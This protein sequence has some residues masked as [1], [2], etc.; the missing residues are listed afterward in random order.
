M[1]VP[2]DLDRLVAAWDA[3]SPEH[4][5]E[6][7]TAD[8]T[9][10]L[11][12]RRTPARISRTYSAAQQAEVDFLDKYPQA[13]AQWSSL[14]ARRYPWLGEL[15][16]A[17][18]QAAQESVAEGGQRAF[19]QGMLQHPV[20][21]AMA[22]L[23]D[24]LS[25]PLRGAT[26]GYVDPT[27]GLYGRQAAKD[28]RGAASR[29]L[30]VVGRGVRGALEL[31]GELA[32]IGAVTK[33]V[34][35]GLGAAGRVLPAVGDLLRATP[36]ATA[37]GTEALG[38]GA[39]AG[40]R[41]PEE[42]GSRL[43]A[44]GKGL[45]MGGLLGGASR[46]SEA[47]T[48]K[49]FEGS[50]AAPIVERGVRAGL[51]VAGG[52]ALGAGETAVR[53]GSAADVLRSAAETGITFGLVGAAHA[54]GRGEKV[55]EQGL[56]ERAK[57]V[58]EA[59]KLHDDAEASGRREDV[60]VAK[61][62]V[63]AA[64]QELVNWRNSKE[65]IVAIHGNPDFK[66]IADENM[67]RSQR[68]SEAGQRLQQINTKLGELTA[69]ESAL[70]GTLEQH[71]HDVELNS[72]LDAVVAERTKL[73]GQVPLLETMQ[74]EHSLIDA[75]AKLK[76]GTV[77]TIRSL[78]WDKVRNPAADV[79]MPDG[80]TKRVPLK[81]LTKVSPQEHAQTAADA[82]A[83]A[84]LKR[85]QASKDPNDQAEF[86]ARTNPPPDASD[87]Q[88]LAADHARKMLGMQP[89]L[90]AGKPSGV[91]VVRKQ[92]I[93]EQL[94]IGRE[95]RDFERLTYNEA[96]SAIIDP[97]TGQLSGKGNALLRRLWGHDFSRWP[98]HIKVLAYGSGKQPLLGE[99][100]GH[101]SLAEQRQRRID[102][103]VRKHMADWQAGRDRKTFEAMSGADQAAAVLGPTGRPT[104]EGFKVLRG[105]YGADTRSWPAWL[106]RLTVTERPALGETE[107]VP[108]AARGR[109]GRPQEPG[110][111][112]T[113]LA[114][115]PGTG[116]LAE[117][118]DE[119]VPFPG[120]TGPEHPPEPQPEPAPE[121]E[122]AVPESEA[123]AAP[124]KEPKPSRVPPGHVMVNAEHVTKAFE[125][126]R[127]VSTQEPVDEGAV[128]AAEDLWRTLAKARTEKAP[129]P[130]EQVAQLG[131]PPPR[132]PLDS[133]AARAEAEGA[134][135]FAQ[136]VI[137]DPK[138]DATSKKMAVR[139]QKLRKT[140]L[141]ALDL[142]DKAADVG[143]PQAMKRARSA[144]DQA[145][146]VLNQELQS[147]SKRVAAGKLK[148][149]PTPE[150]PQPEPP[151]AERGAVTWGS[152][153]HERRALTR[154]YGGDAR[155]A[156]EAWRW[157]NAAG[158]RPDLARQ[159]RTEVLGETL[160]KLREYGLRDDEIQLAQLLE[161]GA[162]L[163]DVHQQVAPNLSMP[164]FVAKAA[165]VNARL[166]DAA[167]EILGK[168]GTVAP[169][170]DS[171]L[172]AIAR[173]WRDPSLLMGRSDEQAVLPTQQRL[174]ELGRHGKGNV[175]VGGV[176]N[177]RR[178]FGDLMSNT[179]AEFFDN[180]F[181]WEAR[182][183]RETHGMLL[184]QKN[185]E[186]KLRSL[187]AFGESGTEGLS[188]SWF[189]LK[190]NQL[191][192]PEEWTF[193]YLD[194][195]RRLNDGQEWT[196]EQA[197]RFKADKIQQLNDWKPGAGRDWNAATT[198]Y[199]KL[200]EHVR[201]RYRQVYGRD[202]STSISEGMYATH[203]FLDDSGNAVSYRK[204]PRYFSDP[205]SAH[206]WSRFE[207]ARKGAQGYVPDVVS[208]ARLYF[209]GMMRKIA[210]D[211][212]LSEKSPLT[213]IVYGDRTTLLRDMGRNA[214]EGVSPE[215]GIA[216]TRAGHAVMDSLNHIASSVQREGHRQRLYAWVKADS[217][218]RLLDVDGNPIK[219]AQA[220][221]GGF[222]Q[223]VRAKPVHTGD[224]TIWLR[225]AR[226]GSQPVE[227]P[228][229]KGNL[230]RLQVHRGGLLE[231]ASNYGQP[232]RLDA[233]MN[234]M[235]RMKLADKQGFWLLDNSLTKLMRTWAY[236]STLGLGQWKPVVNNLA[237]GAFMLTS[238][239]GAKPA[240]EAMA[241][242]TRQM[243]TGGD[244]NTERLLTQ[245]GVL[246][247]KGAILE[248]RGSIAGTA[249]RRGAQ[250]AGEFSFAGFSAAERFLRGSAGLAGYERAH[251]YGRA[252]LDD[253]FG[254]QGV[255][256]D[257]VLTA[258]RG[259][260][261]RADGSELPGGAQLMDLL[262]GAKLH[263]TR[264][265]DRAQIEA[266]L[267][268]R[269]LLHGRA[270][271]AKTQFLYSAAFT[272]DAFNNDVGR[273]LFQ[274]NQYP[275]RAAMAFFDA[276]ANERD[277]RRVARWLAVGLTVSVI[278]HLFD[279]DLSSAI[280]LRVG[281][282]LHDETW[283][284]E[285]DTLLAK[286]KRLA[287]DLIVPFPAPFTMGFPYV[288]LGSQVAL[289]GEVGYSALGLDPSNPLPEDWT[290]DDIWARAGIAWDDASRKLKSSVRPAQWARAM[291]FLNSP[292]DA[293][294]R[295]QV[296]YSDKPGYVTHMTPL[297]FA[298]QEALPGSRKDVYDP[299][300]REEARA[301]RE[302]ERDDISRR[303][304][305]NAVRLGSPDTTPD[306]RD[307]LQRQ[308]AQLLADNPFLKRVSPTDITR[309]ERMSHLSREVKDLTGASLP[310]RVRGYFDWKKAEQPDE[311][312][313]R[314]SL[315]LLF[316]D[317]PKQFSTRF[318]ELAEIDREAALKIRAEWSRIMSR[319]PAG[320][321]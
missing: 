245:L 257:E 175:K 28:V 312:E 197:E 125:R 62:Q 109:T 87:E 41:K 132:A 93:A 303:Y 280:G 157:R 154:A 133:R 202:I 278:A 124:A 23:G 240:A 106:Q 19:E 20:G 42:G 291:E 98:E 122:P 255:S 204:L 128:T 79:V 193:D 17:Q 228:L 270:T 185:A 100:P 269:A 263:Q 210:L 182:S 110:P 223:F 267:H 105:L 101:F 56:N 24:T 292:V 103:A 299:Y 104:T 229:T 242:M 4:E 218:R 121:P 282:A 189:G 99:P 266:E 191:S 30:G 53:G 11:G 209:P 200:W 196:R 63:A 289:M 203:F 32:P 206:V 238:Y 172:R 119:V 316:G 134:M 52:A 59:Q 75:E 187:S 241:R 321:R 81:T 127:K 256:K 304:K 14:K 183:K 36:T 234:W 244:I 3:V 116:V 89:L 57:A 6:L 214:T 147:R 138:A 78:A 92:M 250:K 150:G 179:S 239:V 29:D 49:L 144:Y 167:D 159:F 72:Q 252:M 9:P 96:R 70:R 149:A 298:S 243:T 141:S 71:P 281:D 51:S 130:K 208:V 5:A 153:R 50:A 55:Y 231:L 308:Q 68:V 310:E 288:P 21:A 201:S 176:F 253:I 77:V 148:P 117:Q 16:T 118:G 221:E 236:H 287:A 120:R 295:R 1:P 248:G 69:R 184:A 285:G 237:G 158:E 95:R 73:V 247:E 35:L 31:G 177:P 145:T 165:M 300:R 302:G 90:G 314:D 265:I 290:M 18:A 166:L 311:N 66:D 220:S 181:S 80:S 249:L 178:W 232:G 195:G 37:I 91:E 276:T 271:V 213:Q 275:I 215:G 47:M 13:E 114:G 108:P 190:R 279:R 294:G 45:L 26:A 260:L 84:Y 320:A 74:T 27:A 161:S 283:D 34:G 313:L 171:M 137:D 168:P 219:A 8:V 235:E 60:L 156:E 126:Y 85:L 33:G 143:D 173:N 64:R 315:G 151:R 107:A 170:S 155:K 82:Q 46:A 258:T 286:G 264:Q 188:K 268:Q 293:E 115:V 230:A 58:K 261:Y 180:V 274:L 309:M 198:V 140:Q 306:E 254:R 160:N 102:E 152:N 225:E 233:A 112:G 284:A 212:I 12:E 246:E 164:Q 76:D 205:I 48:A 262:D 226:E 113:G 44:A 317:S 163:Q 65:K 318:K 301:V 216:D 296:S 174:R 135:R 10:L 194:G 39:E 297:E 129:V 88:Q 169:E 227:V 222:F 251:R 83:L 15:R 67:A 111:I 277:P 61:T 211:E 131:Q 199:Q 273:L 94:K 192:I 142:H 38:F 272:P 40:L 22:E 307:F 25:A 305:A 224:R 217:A 86:Q 136:G 162:D 43:A 146:R 54:P 139:E 97:A 186:S 319:Q 2:T 259:K 7:S 123:P 207:Q